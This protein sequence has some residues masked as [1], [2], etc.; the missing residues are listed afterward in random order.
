[1]THTVAIR[2][3]DAA[4]VERLLDRAFGADRH[5]RTAY[6]LRE[7]TA[8]IADLSFALVEG[9]ALLGSIQCWPVRFAGD[10]GRIVP[11]VLVGPVAV[12]PAR[13]QEGLGRRLM[14]QALAAADQRALDLMLIGDPDYYGRFFGFT[15]AATA[16]WRLPGPVERHRLLARGAGVPT[17]AGA[18]G[19]RVAAVA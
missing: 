15:A 18:I 9:D 13:Q 2:D 10:D 12:A 19:P 5:L 17:G 14:T 6:R 7:G 16:A 1:M 3:V 11:L 4:A 8:A